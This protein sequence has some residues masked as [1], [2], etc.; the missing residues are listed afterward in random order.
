[1]GRVPGEARDVGYRV[2]VVSPTR[3]IDL[4]YQ[5]SLKFFQQHPWNLITL[6]DKKHAEIFLE[7]VEGIILVVPLYSVLVSH[8]GWVTQGI[9]DYDEAKALYDHYNT[10]RYSQVSMWS[11]LEPDPILMEDHEG[12][13]E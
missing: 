8:I 11:S 13:L 3:E 7:V 5:G 9:S 4:E 1:M 10:G 2:R 6:Q 12:G